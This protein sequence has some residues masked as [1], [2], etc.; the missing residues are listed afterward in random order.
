MVET[1]TGAQAEWVWESRT[2]T[3]LRELLITNYGFASTI[4]NP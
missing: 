3:P 4:H 1:G 2:E